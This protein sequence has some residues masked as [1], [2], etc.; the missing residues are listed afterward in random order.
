M[1]TAFVPRETREGN[2][3]ARDEWLDRAL[4]LEAEGKSAGMVNMALNKAIEFENYAVA[5]PK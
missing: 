1:A 2:F 5:Q 3:T 4:R